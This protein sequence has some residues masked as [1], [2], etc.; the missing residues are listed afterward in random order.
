MKK[1]IY[2][3]LTL[4]LLILTTLLTVSCSTSITVKNSQVNELVS[5][6]KKKDYVNNTDKVYIRGHIYVNIYVEED[7][8]EN[9]CFEILDLT[10]EF[11]D[12]DT[13]NKLI[14]ELKTVYPLDI[15][16]LIRNNEDTEIFSFSGS[17]YKPLTAR[18]SPPDFDQYKWSYW[19]NETQSRVTY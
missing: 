10:K 14:T 3:Y 1:I 5:E 12:I 11:F 16:I 15:E 8:A 2:K 17:C 6:I 19:D 4:I 7:A 18:N 9:N 13:K